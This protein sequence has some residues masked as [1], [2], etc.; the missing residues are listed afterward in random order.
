MSSTGHRNI[1]GRFDLVS[2][3]ESR[4][5]IRCHLDLLYD[6]EGHGN[7]YVRFDLVYDPKR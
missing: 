7:F 3:I 6:S 4:R 5:V 1:C 2:D